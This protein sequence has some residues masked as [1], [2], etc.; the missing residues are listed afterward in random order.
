M[1]K[2]KE[3]IKLKRYNYSDEKPVIHIRQKR[4][5]IIKTYFFSYPSLLHAS[6]V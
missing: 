2:M 1:E 4:I 3:N 6:R 5:K